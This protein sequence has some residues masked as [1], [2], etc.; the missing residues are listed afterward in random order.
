[1]T[2]TVLEALVLIAREEDAPLLGAAAAFL[3]GRQ[4]T[5]G[6]WRSYWWSG[7]TYATLH[8]LS[9]LNCFDGADD[10]AGRVP[11]VRSSTAS[12][13]TGAGRGATD[14]QC[15]AGLLRRRVRS[16]P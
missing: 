1:M 15:R 12:W 16:S 3:A 8:G 14:S 10:R 4:G 13:S 7:V 5:D 6:L 9:A 11:H 2:A